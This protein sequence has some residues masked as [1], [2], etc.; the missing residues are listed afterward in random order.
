MKD[1]TQLDADVDAMLARF[2]TL[3][4]AHCRLFA[5]VH[6]IESR[7]E[8]QPEPK[9]ETPV[10]SGT[11]E[12]GWIRFMV[13]TG[14]DLEG[15]RYAIDTLRK[16]QGALA[17]NVG[18]LWHSP[19]TDK[20]DQRILKLEQKDQPKPKPKT[21]PEPTVA[22]KAFAKWGGSGE[23]EV[24]YQAGFHAGVKK[25]AGFAR[26]EAAVADD[27]AKFA[28]AARLRAIVLQMEKALLD[29]PEPSDPK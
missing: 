20:L 3:N 28:L 21:P 29:P 10:K 8:P 14:N 7:S 2:H 13:R 22:W 16:E 15:M 1:I 24:S 19:V 9:P 17:T 5:K 12:P 27:T 26:T 23:E 25:S 4:E 11:N 6:R 18:T